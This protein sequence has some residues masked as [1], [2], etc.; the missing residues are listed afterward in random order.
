MNDY[1]L[2]ISF[3][4]GLVLDDPFIIASSH[5]TDSA[6]AFEHLS[7]IN[8]AAITTKTISKRFGGNKFTSKPPRTLKQI[9]SWSNNNIGIYVDGPKETELWGIGIAFDLLIEA[10]RILPKTKIGISVLQGEDYKEIKKSLDDNYD[11][12][13]LNLKYALRLYEDKEKKISLVINEIKSDI[14][15]FCKTFLDYPKFIKFSRETYSFF[16]ELLD[17]DILSIIHEKNVAV[18][19]ANSK[20]MDAPPSYVRFINP[21]IITK[22]VIVGD[23]LFPETY[24]IIKDFQ[25]LNKDIEIIAN[26]GIMSI[27]E[28]IDCITCGIKSFQI[29][30]LVH[31]KGIYVIE[32]LRRQLMSC[33][34]KFNCANLDD[35]I[36]VAKKNKYGLEKVNNLFISKEKLGDLIKNKGLKYLNKSLL[37]EISDDFKSIGTLDNDYPYNIKF[38]G[39]KGSILSYALSFYLTSF[40]K[41]EISIGSSKEILKAKDYDS[42]IISNAY[43]EEFKKENSNWK[44]TKI[45]QVKYGLMSINRDVSKIRKVF[46]FESEGS[47]KAKIELQKYKTFHFEYLKPEELSPLLIGWDESLAILAKYPLT[48]LYKFLLPEELQNDWEENFSIIT[49][50]WLCTKNNV[51]LLNTLIKDLQNLMKLISSNTENAITNLLKFGFND[52]LIDLLTEKK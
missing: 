13:E 3:N 34:K 25:K 46:L 47:E 43:L 1:S 44:V 41:Y 5:L 39:T 42:V 11:F 7:P 26:G 6:K 45:G 9:S 35:F 20:K 8:P 24:N 48:D 10:K 19:I 32:M 33:M 27:G 52:Y 15:D 12:V 14:V 36:L 4:N 21:E 18:I 22:G 31:R 50:I 29:C 17:S 38:A 30:T 16:S 28:I 2:K 23:Y 51:T 40:N 49:Y 37:N